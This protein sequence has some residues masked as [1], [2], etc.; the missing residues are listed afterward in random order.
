MYKLGK[1]RNAGAKPRLKKVSD[2]CRCF[3]ALLERKL[4][5]QNSVRELSVLSGREYERG[6]AVPTLFRSA[7]RANL[8]VFSNHGKVGIQ[9]DAHGG[10]KRN[11]VGHTVV[12][13]A[14]GRAQLLGV[15]LLVNFGKET[16]DVLHVSL[17]GVLGTH[18]GQ[19]V[20]HGELSAKKRHNFVLLEG[21]TLLHRNITGPG[22][23]MR[24]ALNKDQ[25]RLLGSIPA[26][27]DCNGVW[28]FV[29]AAVVELQLSVVKVHRGAELRVA[30]QG[31]K[32]MLKDRQVLQ[33]N[34]LNL[35]DILG[36]HP[37]FGG[38]TDKVLRSGTFILT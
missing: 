32:V 34:V 8:G 27:A 2:P 26:E 3:F 37:V 28:R 5:L 18:L 16:T 11:L 13:S 30:L 7:V 17:R 9:G 33:H 22:V 24:L 12:D 29:K 36:T 10:V 20:L 4:H 1:L 38:T 15:D 21:E 6:V 23:T 14:H 25:F 19:L 31:V 35:R